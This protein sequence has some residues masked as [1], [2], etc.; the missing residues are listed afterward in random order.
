M[1]DYSGNGHLFTDPFLADEYDSDNA[2]L[3]WER[4]IDF[5]SHV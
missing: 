5:C 4:V 3:L 1:F 2:Q